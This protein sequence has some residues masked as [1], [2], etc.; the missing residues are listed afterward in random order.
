MPLGLEFYLNI[1]HR[2][3]TGI[4]APCALE[5]VDS[6]LAL[7]NL[8]DKYVGA[9]ADSASLGRWLQDLRREVLAYDHPIFF[10]RG[11]RD[12]LLASLSDSEILPKPFQGEDDYRDDLM[13]IRFEAD[14]AKL[15]SR[16]SMSAVLAAAA[17]LLMIHRERLHNFG[18]FAS[19]VSAR[20]FFHGFQRAH[21]EARASLFD[22]LLDHLERLW[23]WR[24]PTPNAAT[25]WKT[26]EKVRVLSSSLALLHW[27]RAERL[28]KPGGFPLPPLRGALIGAYEALMKASY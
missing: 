19:V 18:Q 20:N 6:S 5:V 4:D 14:L 2:F 21:S 17:G 13:R 8:R 3:A 25:H 16:E 1:L 24:Q 23:L 10:E 22:E 11:A 12:R 27:S 28:R 15:V 9:S 7:L 26:L